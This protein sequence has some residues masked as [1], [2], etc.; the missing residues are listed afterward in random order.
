MPAL[1]N[2]MVLCV[3]HAIIASPL[4][5]FMSLENIVAIDKICFYSFAGVFGIFHVFYMPY[6]IYKLLKHKRVKKMI[7]SA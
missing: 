4:L 3:Y 2:L 6:F 1:I 7:I 5:S